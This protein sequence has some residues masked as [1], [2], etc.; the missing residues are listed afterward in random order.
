ME[1]YDAADG[2]LMRV[3][4][5]F[6]PIAFNNCNMMTHITVD[7][8]NDPWGH[9]EQQMK[10]SEEDPLIKTFDCYRPK[11]VS[12]HKLQVPDPAC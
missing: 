10:Q 5:H 1:L 7:V 6:A 9:Q 2:L 4:F 3:N 12:E 11:Q 8:T